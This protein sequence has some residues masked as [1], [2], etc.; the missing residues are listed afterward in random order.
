M[1]RLTRNALA[2]TPLE[3]EQVKAMYAWDGFHG[4]TAVR[5]LCESHERLRMELE[6]ATRAAEEINQM[7]QQVAK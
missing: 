1:D 2:R 4:E 7:L 6:G 5:R 3:P